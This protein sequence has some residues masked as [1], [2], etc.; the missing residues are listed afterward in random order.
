MRQDHSDNPLPIM[1]LVAMRL[2]EKQGR[3]HASLLRRANRLLARRYGTPRLNNKREAISELVFIILSARTQGRNHEAAYRRLRHRFHTW[4]AVRDAAPAAV[5]ETIRD[6]GLG[7]L[8]T[9][10][11]QGL[12]AKITADF[13]RLSGTALRRLDDPELEQYLANLPGVGLK[14]ARCVML[15]AFDRRVFPVDTHCMRLFEN[16][17]LIPGRL[18]F[19]YAQDPLQAMVPERL[20]Y[21][22]HVNAV[23]H[24]RQTCTP[25]SPRCCVCPIR[26]ICVNRSD[27]RG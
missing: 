6:A 18:R 16:L 25:A 27:R 21:S 19:E 23:A 17:G 13:G 7:Q 5:R 12:L 14:T 3:T 20:R 11:I 10:Q 9:E 15:Y 24:G 4:A 22:L 2:K 26:T 8:K 1:S